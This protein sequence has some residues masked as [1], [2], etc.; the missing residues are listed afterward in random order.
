MDA[1]KYEPKGVEKEERVTEVRVH[2]KTGRFDEAGCGS[3]IIMKLCEDFMFENCHKFTLSADTFNFASG[4][5]TMFRLQD[6][7][8]SR[9]EIAYAKIWRKDSSTWLVEGIKIEHVI[10]TTYSD[11]K[12]KKHVELAYWNPCVH[13][14]LRQGS[15]GTRF[16]PGDVAICSIVETGTMKRAPVSQPVWLIFPGYYDED[17]THPGIMDH[18]GRGPHLEDVGG[19]LGLDLK[20]GSHND[21]NAGAITSYGDYSWDQDPFESTEGVPRGVNV[22]MD[23]SGSGNCD[24][25]LQ[26]LQVYVLKPAK[27]FRYDED[28][29]PDD[30]CEAIIEGTI[31]YVDKELTDGEGWLRKSSRGIE[32]HIGLEFD[33]PFKFKSLT[34]W[35]DKLGEREFGMIGEKF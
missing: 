16:G 5:E 8:V 28:C 17:R 2:I 33:E 26:H 14:W 29:S 35:T 31:H 21:F 19:L 12:E 20:W 7:N 9:D 27:N 34:E 18:V 1:D 25:Y 22:K 3:D 32:G 4:E 6:L 30:M 10:T 24:W 13:K 15:K 23:C 11:G